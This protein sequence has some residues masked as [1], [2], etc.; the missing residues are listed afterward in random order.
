[1]AEK[2]IQGAVKRPG[3]LHRDLG[4]PQGQPIPE[5][6]L[7]EALHSSNPK[8]RQRANFAR[9]VRRLGRGR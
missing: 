2:W 6:R 5:A 7:Q 9:N 1:M 3:E 8:V 4:I